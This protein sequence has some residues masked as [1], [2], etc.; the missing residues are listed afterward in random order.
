MNV[1]DEPALLPRL[2]RGHC[3]EWIIVGRVAANHACERGRHLFLDIEESHVT[4]RIGVAVLL[5]PI[6]KETRFRDRIDRGV[7]KLLVMHESALGIGD[8]H[9]GGIQ[10]FGE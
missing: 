5:A 4:Q 3:V 9:V 6:E 7:E 8:D 10:I 2:D 1:D